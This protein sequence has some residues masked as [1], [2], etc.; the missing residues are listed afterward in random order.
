MRKMKRMK[1]LGNKILFMCLCMSILLG[2]VPMTVM[3]A[4]DVEVTVEK[5]EELAAP[6]EF[7]AE[8]MMQVYIATGKTVN[9][10]GENVIDYSDEFLKVLVDENKKVYAHLETLTTHLDMEVSYFETAVDIRYRSSAVY[11]L[12]GDTVA[13]F[14]TPF[15]DVWIDMKQ[16]PKLYEEEWYVPL[17]A[18]LQLTGTDAFYCG[19]NALGK[20][21]LYLVP[22]QQTVIEDL[23]DV[24]QNIYNKY[25]FNFIKDFNYSEDQTGKTTGW[26]SVV[27]YVEGLITLDWRAYYEAIHIPMF[28]KSTDQFDD[29]AVDDFMTNVLKVHPGVAEAVVRNAKTGMDT[30]DVMFDVIADESDTNIDNYSSALKSEL[31]NMPADEIYQNSKF[32][33]TVSAQSKY[34]LL[35]AYEKC[36]GY[37]K[38]AEGLN[39]LR[40]Q[41]SNYA[42][43]REGLCDYNSMSYDGAIYINQYWEPIQDSVIKENNKERILYNI[44]LYQ[45]DLDENARLKY[46]NEHWLELFMGILSMANVPGVGAVNLASS[47]T[48][49]AKD[50]IAGKTLEDIEYYR[51]A[52][53][54]FVYE[55]DAIE[56]M[57]KYIAQYIEQEKGTSFNVM[58][59]EEEL[60]SVVYHTLAASY[61]TREMAMNG[62]KAYLY[63]NPKYKEQAIAL[64][65]EIADIMARLCDLENCQMG[66]TPTELRNLSISEHE[67][68]DNVIFNLVQ[69]QGEI[70][71]LENEKP[72]KKVK[73]EVLDTVGNLLAEFETHDEGT[74]DIAFELEDVDP[75]SEEP[76]MIDLTLRMKYKRYEEL[77]ETVE[78]QVFHN[79][80]IDG[81]RVGEKEEVIKGYLCGA[82]T[83]DGKTML[84]IRRITIYD[85]EIYFDLQEW[86]DLYCRTYAIPAGQ[87]E[88]SDLLERIVLEDDVTFE[89]VYSKMMPDGSILGGMV[90]IMDAYLNDSFMP[91]ELIEDGLHNADEIQAFVDAYYEANHEYPTFE[92]TKVNSVANHLEPIMVVIDN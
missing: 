79:S 14:Q 27:Q 58:I 91:A 57:R 67:H 32:E 3:A 39:L 41:A 33:L 86:S 21:A 70:L 8:G 44:D 77:L 52:V 66:R 36:K 64:N 37:L 82:K 71:S 65:E 18:F 78:V 80:R 25:A 9:S 16:A 45:G 90:N 74:F 43:I 35:D 89:T 61:T 30:L 49:A 42:Q 29:P 5:L 85:E 46:V 88:V 31:D 60:R 68:F 51:A 48:S 24:Y 22:P 10:N 6:T 7:P 76:I 83:F 11:M 53:F 55:V 73:V 59:S 50:E 84:D 4:E 81:L 69:I 1:R 2:I 63:L 56:V 40:K 62:C 75:F 92:I 38:I 20:Q 28:G 17:D 72:A 13:G 19:E 12:L 15:D 34:K 47:V 87:G 23:Y 54:G 26:A